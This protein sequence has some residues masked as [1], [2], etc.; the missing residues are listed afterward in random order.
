MMCVV[1]FIFAVVVDVI[2]EMSRV[3]VLSELLYADNLVMVSEM[4]KGLGFEC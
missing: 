3:G 2:T 4:M 1:T